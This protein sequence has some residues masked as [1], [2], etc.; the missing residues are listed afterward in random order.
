MIC[1][2]PV[3]ASAASWVRSSAKWA[4]RMPVWIAARCRARLSREWSRSPSAR[5]AV[6]AAAPRSPSPSRRLRR[7]CERRRSSRPSPYPAERG[8]SARAVRAS[9]P[10]LCDPSARDARFIRRVRALG[11]EHGAVCAVRDALTYAPE[12]SQAV[13][14]AASD[15]EKVGARCGGRECFNR[16]AGLERK[17]APSYLQDFIYGAI[18]GAVTTFA[19]GRRGGG[20]EPRREGRDHPRS[21][22]LIADGFSMAVS[23]LLGSRAERQ[24]RE[25][26]RREEQLRIRVLRRG[27]AR[28]SRSCCASP[29]R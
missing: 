20:G 5:E 23:N 9:V 15:D 3:R 8:V 27:A 10:P 11:D 25:R 21:A 1:S 16:L 17:P 2:A 13:E 4:A 6:L 18:D 12:G 14:S 29:R 22:N 19:G 28:T 7:W 26:A 24:R